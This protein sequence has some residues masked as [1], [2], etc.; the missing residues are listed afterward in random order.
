[1]ST[2]INFW[3]V[4]SAVFCVS[5]RLFIIVIE[6]LWSFQ[7]DLLCL[8]TWGYFLIQF[9][10]SLSYHILPHWLLPLCLAVLWYILPVKLWIETNVIIISTRHVKFPDKWIWLLRTIH[11]HLEKI[12]IN[13]LRSIQCKESYICM[14][15]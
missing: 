15:C 9:C 2:S 4:F 6:S 11:L 13:K 3:H 7:K 8:D 12:I 10:S 5:L 14:L 1:M